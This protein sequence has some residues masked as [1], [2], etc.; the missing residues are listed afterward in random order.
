MGVFLLSAQA[1]YSSSVSV[2]CCVRRTDKASQPLGE[3]QNVACIRNPVFVTGTQTR[4]RPFSRGPARQ[5]Q[6]LRGLRRGVLLAP[7]HRA[8]TARA[9]GLRCRKSHEKGAESPTDGSLC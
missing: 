5:L 2:P 6:L 4:N 1:A 9:S 8:P 7:L 3:G